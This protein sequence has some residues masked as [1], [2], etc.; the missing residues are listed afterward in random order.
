MS[1]IVNDVIRKWTIEQH[2]S[3]PCIFRVT[4]LHPLILICLTKVVQLWILLWVFFFS[5]VNVSCFAD[6]VKNRGFLSPPTNHHIFTTH[7][8]LIGHRALLFCMTWAKKPLL[9]TL[10]VTNRTD[11]PLWV[12]SLSD[13][14]WYEEILEL[15]KKNILYRVSLRSFLNLLD[16]CER[17]WCIWQICLM[18]KSVKIGNSIVA[19]KLLNNI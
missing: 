9:N 8:Q 6:G 3:N 17:Y 4:K 12:Y 19:V 13:H 10:V 2:K 7:S 5:S 11:T 16:Y 15:S 1:S 18:R 14:I